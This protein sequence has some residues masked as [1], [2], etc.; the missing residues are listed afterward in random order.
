LDDQSRIRAFVSIDIENPNILSQ[1]TSIT[2]DLLKIGGDIKP[3]ETENIHLTLKFLGYIPVSKIASIKSS[4]NTVE[5]PRTDVEVVGLGAFPNLNRMN[6]IWIGISKGWTEIEQIYEQTEKIFD[7]L[8]FPRETRP[9]SPHITIARVRSSRK[10]HEMSEFLMK[11]ADEKFGT[12]Q[13]TS[14]RLKQSILASTG[15][16]Y[17]TLHEIIAKN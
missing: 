9:F 2:N 15:P 11:C 8:G 17:S 4:L 10:R 3:V 12:V 6:V 13:L 14:I 16:T 1:I 5:F 7:T